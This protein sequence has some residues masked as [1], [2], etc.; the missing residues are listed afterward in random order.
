M[1][2]VLL[3][4]W[5]LMSTNARNAAS[6]AQPVAWALVRMGY[7]LK[8][9]MI[10][11]RLKPGWVFVFSDHLEIFDVRMILSVRSKARRAYSLSGDAIKEVSV[12]RRVRV[13]FDH[14]FMNLADG[15]EV[16]IEITPKNG[17][18]VRGARRGELEEIA[19]AIREAS[20]GSSDRV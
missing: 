19:S 5:G 11:D 9:D 14:V 7:V 13:G 16:E 8:D 10:V 3:R 6:L 1:A 20:G 12:D 17:W 15:R 2:F 4:Q 18:T